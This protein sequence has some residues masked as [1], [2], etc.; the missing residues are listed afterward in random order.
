MP[1]VFTDE[2]L[3][4]QAIEAAKRKFATYPSA[5]ANG[6]MVREYKRRY[7]AKKGRS[8]GAFKGRSDSLDQWFAEDWKAINSS[9]K[10]VGDCGSGD[11]K[12][13]VK[14][15]PASKARSLS[16]K[17]R[18]RLAKRKQAQDPNPGRSGSPVMVSSKLDAMDPAVLA[19]A[20]DSI[21]QKYGMR[22]D[23]SIEKYIVWFAGRNTGTVVHATSRS[24]AIS[25]AREKKVTGWE[26]KVDAARLCTDRELAMVK[27]GTWIRTRANGKETGG[28]YKFRSW[29]KK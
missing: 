14:C 20:I 12:G 3:H 15:L 6:W 29:M 11:T 17:D 1:L 23:A 13:K 28:A 16:K 2:K 19:R 22:L 21:E 18:S 8:S 4:Q 7:L 9:G 10:I 26:G 24:S 27:K 5:Y 25:H